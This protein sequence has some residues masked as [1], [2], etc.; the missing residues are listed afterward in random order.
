MDMLE[1]FRTMAVGRETRMIRL[2]EEINQLLMQ[3]GLEKKYKIVD[4]EGAA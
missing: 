1:R 3:A 4:K 2:R